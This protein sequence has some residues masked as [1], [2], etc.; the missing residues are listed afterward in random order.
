[1]HI[2]IIEGTSTDKIRYS[3]YSYLK[4]KYRKEKLNDRDLCKGEYGGAG[5]EGLQLGRS[6]Q[7]MSEEGRDG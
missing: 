1:M 2:K 7:G 4:D 3:C 6:D 5:K